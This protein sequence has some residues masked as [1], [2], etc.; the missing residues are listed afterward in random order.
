M[1]SNAD[2]TNDLQDCDVP[3]PAAVTFEDFADIDSMLCESLNL[4]K[5]ARSI[6]GDNKLCL[7]IFFSAKTH[8]PDCPLRVIVSENGAWQKNLGK[9][10]QTHLNVLDI[11]DPFQVK[12]SEQVIDYL[13]DRRGGSFTAI[14]VDI[15]DL[16]YSIPHDDLLSDVRDCIEAHGA[17]KFQNAS[18]VAVSSF[19]ELLDTYLNSTFAQFEDHIVSQRNGICIGSCVAPV[20]SDICLGV[21]DRKIRERCSEFGIDEVFRFVDDFLV[22]LND[23]N[24]CAN[25]RVPEV[26]TMFSECLRP[27][28]VTHERPANGH[29]RFLDL[30]LYFGSDHVCWACEPRGKKP[31]LPYA[32]AHSKL[33]KRAI[34]KSCFVSALEKTCG[35]RK[36]EA[37]RSQ[38]GRL[39]QAGYPAHLLIAVAEGILKQSRNGPTTNERRTKAAV[40]PYLHAVSHKLKRIGNRAGI[41]IFFSAPKKL[42]QLCRGVNSDTEREPDCVTRHRPRLVDCEKDVVY[43]I[44]LS[45]GSIY[46]GQTG[47]C[48][49]TRLQEHKRNLRDP[50]S[51]ELALHCSKCK[52]CTPALESTVILRKCRDTTTR[53]IAEALAI[54]KCADKCVSNPSVCLSEKEMSFLNGNDRT[55]DWRNGRQFR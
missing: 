13:K 22:I 41:D 50:N 54:S 1:S 40:I 4:D 35:H 49:N 27:L 15:K 10:L 5:L 33:V 48:L 26:L 24:G 39:E 3:I 32:S 45:C 23:E 30:G 20:L 28:E 19:L 25:T 16:Y 29:I 46:I 38:V 2:I 11:D 53:L 14:S 55:K 52:G 17:V 12:G 6:N 44:P 43:S 51:G 34:V 31:V 7:D 47:R 21:R 37:F 18:G 36:E 42:H 9:F 8:K